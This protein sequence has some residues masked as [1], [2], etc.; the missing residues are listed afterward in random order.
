LFNVQ[1]ED[2]LAVQS[3]L[4][5]QNTSVEVMQAIEDDFS[6]HRDSPLHTQVSEYERCRAVEHSGNSLQNLDRMEALFNIS[7][8][9]VRK[10]I[11]GCLSRLLRN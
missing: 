7:G 10:S 3:R 8:I 9:L 1:D 2:V 4:V 5:S 11:P 6:S